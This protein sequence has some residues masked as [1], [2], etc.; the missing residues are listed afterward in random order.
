MDFELLAARLVKDILHEL[1]MLQQRETVLLFTGRD[2][3]LPE[4]LTELL[5]P[6]ARV[7]YPEDPWEMAEVDRFILPCLHIDQMVDLAL[8]KGG[9]RLMYAVRR[10]LLT[11]RTVEV[12]QFEYRR[13]LDTAPGSLITLYEQYRQQLA[14][15]GLIDCVLRKKQT[16]RIDKNVLTA[17]DILWARDQGAQQLDLAGNCRVTPLAQETARDLGIHLSTD[18]GGRT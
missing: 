7:L 2:R 15:F 9:S 11:G 1:Q 14:G 3:R 17:A 4:G 8:G 5:D 16:A 18:T 13:Y 10:V 12:F 6:K